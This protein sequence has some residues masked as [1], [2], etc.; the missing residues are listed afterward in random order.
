MRLLAIYISLILLC[1][2]SFHAFTQNIQKKYIR[3]TERITNK[4]TSFN[5]QGIPLKTDRLSNK[6]GDIV[7]IYDEAMPDSIQIALSAAKKLW[8]S[9]LT[10]IHPIYLH[11]SFESLGEG[12]SMIADAYCY[13]EPNLSLKGCPTAL[14]SQINNSPCS[15]RYSPDGII[16]FNSDVEWNCNFSNNATSEYNLPTMALRGIARCLG[17][18]SSIMESEDKENDFIYCFGYP[19]FFDKLLYSNNT[20]L[21]QLSESSIDMANFVKSNNVYAKTKSQNHKIYAPNRYVRDLSLCFFDD[22]NSLMSYSIGQG[23]VN[24]SIDDKTSSILEAI[25]WELPSSGLKIKCNDIS[26]NGIGSSYTTHTFSLLKGNESISKY[27]WRL[28]LKDKNGN[29]SQIYNNSTE[30][31]TIPKISS[32]NNYFVNINGDMEGRIECDYITNGKQYSAI[33]FTLYLE[34]KPSIISID[35][36]SKVNHGQFE[37]SLLF[38]VSYTGADYVTVEI[39]EEYNTTLRSYRFDEPYIAHIKTGN[40]TNLYYSWVTISVSNKYGSTTETFEYEPTYGALKSM[41]SENLP[42][43]SNIRKIILFNLE[44]DII[45]DGEPEVFFNKNFKSGIYIRKDIYVNGLSKTS[46]FIL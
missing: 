34:L 1:T 26:D 35:N 5:N 31:F 37:F 22:T 6:S 24:L 44:G 11:I 21:S 2:T 27:N 17:F 32:S 12:I 45:F 38:N 20:A 18:G 3:Y 30:T 19:T 42:N 13:E 41:T 46:K 9:K 28:F 43:I 8:E 16:I 36:V 29:Y 7:L 39:E 33:P 10:T 14:A 4:S 23:N 25:G 15:S 40:I